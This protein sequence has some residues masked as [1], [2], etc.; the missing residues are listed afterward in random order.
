MPSLADKLGGITRTSERLPDGRWKEIITPAR[1]SGFGPSTVILTAGQHEKY[2]RWLET[3]DDIR[4]V[5]PEL[6]LDVQEALKS[7]IGADEWE[8]A[9]AP[10][11]EPQEPEEEI[12]DDEILAAAERMSQP[13]TD[14][15]L[16]QVCKIG[17]GA[18][19]CRYLTM[20]PHLGWS[21]EKH[22]VHKRTLDQRVALGTMI[23]RG[24]NCEG[25]LCR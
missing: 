19:C 5:F 7:G 2:L 20:A 13:I 8:E 17:Q 10:R 14:E 23:A 25:R 16:N 21:C 4:G 6:S 3:R 22:G 15:H 1:W 18:T 11:E 12:Q 9:F 24:D